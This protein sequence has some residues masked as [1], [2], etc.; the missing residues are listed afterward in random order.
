MRPLSL[1]RHAAAAT[2]PG[3]RRSVWGLA[4][5]ALLVLTPLMLAGCGKPTFDRD[6]GVFVF[7]RPGK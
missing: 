5:C 2:P 4:L 7:Q 1:P 3:Q 6:R